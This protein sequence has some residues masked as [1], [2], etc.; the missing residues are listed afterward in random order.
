MQSKRSH[1]TSC[2]K[3]S[4]HYFLGTLPLH[5][6]AISSLLWL[7]PRSSVNTRVFIYLKSW[8]VGHMQFCR[9]SYIDLILQRGLQ[10]QQV[11]GQWGKGGSNV[12]FPLSC[13]SLYTYIYTLAH[14]HAQ[15]LATRKGSMT[16]TRMSGRHK[17]PSETVKL[18]N[19]LTS[20][21][22]KRN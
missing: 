9:C 14:T 15:T 11:C 17:T 13:F 20:Q 7:L 2:I 6:V 3:L 4:S 12:C 22:K 21:S 10:V 8:T 19:I 16:A 18:R 5:N 1:I